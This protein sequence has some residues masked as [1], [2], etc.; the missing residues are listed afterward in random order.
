MMD[1]QN[2]RIMVKIEEHVTTTPGGLLMPESSQPAVDKRFTFR[3]GKVIAAGPGRIDAT[4]E[5]G[6]KP[7]KIKVGDRICFHDGAARYV[8]YK[9]E[10][11]VLMGADSVEAKVPQNADCS[12]V[13]FVKKVIGS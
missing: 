6:I 7:M 9:A 2:D 3:F 1:M 8:K 5:G 12:Q 11:Y 13:V 10:D 4:Y